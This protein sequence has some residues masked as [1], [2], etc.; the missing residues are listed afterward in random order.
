MRFILSLSAHKISNGTFFG[1]VI[2][3][4]SLK[5]GEYGLQAVYDFACLFVCFCFFFYISKRQQ[6][7]FMPFKYRGETTNS[8]FDRE[9]TVIYLMTLF[10]QRLKHDS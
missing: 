10:N 6:K 7:P 3:T 2:L 1:N 8:H 4:G 9:K 5:K